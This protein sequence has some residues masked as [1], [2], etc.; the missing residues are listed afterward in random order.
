MIWLL[1][2]GDK[3]HIIEYNGIENSEIKVD[4]NAV[5]SKGITSWGLV[6]QK[7]FKLN[8]ESIKIRRR[9]LLSEEWDLVYK[10]QTYAYKMK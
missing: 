7:S 10:E 1:N 2:A 8:G 3:D 4:G 5:K 6:V 9:D